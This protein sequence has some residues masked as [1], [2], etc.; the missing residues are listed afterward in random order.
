MT[1]EGIT[2][3]QARRM[4]AVTAFLLLA[5]GAAASARE[6]DHTHAAFDALLKAQ[7]SDGQVDYRALKAAPAALNAYLDTLAAVREREFKTWREAQRIAFL[8]NL[9]NAATLKLIVDHYPVESIKD[10][11]SIFSGPWDQK[12]VRL[13]GKTVTLNNL[14][15][16]ILRKDYHEPRLHMALVCAAKGCPPLRS[17]AYVAERLNGQLDDQ[18]RV[19][20][21]S[22]TGMR[23]DRAKSEVQLSA[24]FK[25]YGVDFTSVPAFVSKHSGQNVNGLKIRYVNYDWSLNEP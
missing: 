19:Y 13:F 17:E 18:S 12:V 6:F 2:H 16:D 23:L 3:T 4:G 20:L 22:P 21:T 15:H 9:Y 14:E 1:P 25:W 8:A 10:I 24:I 7:V 5:F 11:G